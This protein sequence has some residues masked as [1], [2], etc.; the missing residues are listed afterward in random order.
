M[1]AKK[2]EPKNTK[3]QTL[4][5]LQFSDKKEKMLKCLEATIFNISESCKGAGISRATY[6]NWKKDDPDFEEAVH[7]LEEG[8]K[9]FVE[10]K[11]LDLIK[12]GNPTAIIFYLKTKAKDRGYSER[13]ETSSSDPVADFFEAAAKDL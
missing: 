4:Q 3:P 1:R 5:I 9:D 11:L 12:D 6:Y 8:Q 10:S 13:Q 2:V 7:D